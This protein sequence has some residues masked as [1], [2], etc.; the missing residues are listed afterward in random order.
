MALRKWVTETLL[1][2]QR[3]T[4]FEGLA[5][6]FLERSPD[7]W[8]EPRAARKLLDE[9]RGFGAMGQDGLFAIPDGLGYLR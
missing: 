5:D 1:L 3:M 2:P 7:G 4:T 8:G 9:Q 6:G